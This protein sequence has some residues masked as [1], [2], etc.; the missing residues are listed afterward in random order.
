MSET[1]FDELRGRI[2][3]EGFLTGA[4]GFTDGLAAQAA[5]AAHAVLLRSPSTRALPC[6]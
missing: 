4:G 5:D 6:L 3:D 1:D 2:E